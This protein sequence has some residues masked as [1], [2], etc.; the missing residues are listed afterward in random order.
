MVEFDVVR[1][2]AYYFKISN[3]GVLRFLVIQECNF[4]C[5]CKVAI[6]ALDG[7][8]DRICSR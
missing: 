3:Y 4:V 1:C 5:V 2:F 8:E 6:N 7:F